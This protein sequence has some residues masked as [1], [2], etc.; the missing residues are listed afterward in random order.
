MQ[1]AYGVLTSGRAID[2][3]IGAAGTG[4]TRVVAAIAG[5]WCQAGAGR[6]IGLTTSTNASHVLAAEGLTESHNFARFLGR[7]KDSDQTLGHLPVA[8]GDLLVV[9]EASMVST[10]DLAAVEEIATRRGAKILLTGDPAQLSAPQAGGVM[11]LLAD[12][13]GYYQLA[14]VQRFEQDWERDASLRLRAGDADALADYDQRGRILDGTREQ[15]TETAYQRWL[16]DHLSGTP[17]LLLVTTNAQA[18]ELARRA[19]DELAALGMVATD[20]LIELRDGNLAGAGDLIVARQNDRIVAGEPGR[21]LANRD[22]LR[23]DGWEEIGEAR[24][25]LVRRMTGRHRRTGNITWSETFELPEDVHRAARR[26]GICRE[27]PH[28]GRPDGRHRAPGRGRNGQPRVVLRRHEPRPRTQH[29]L[30]H[31]RTRP[32][33][34]PHSPASARTRHRGPR[35]RPRLAAALAPPRRP[36]GRPGPGT[37]P[38]DRHRN[39]APR[40][41]PGRQ[42]GHPRPDLGRRDPHPRHAPLRGCPPLAAARPALGAIPAGPRTRHAH[43]AAAHR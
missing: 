39:D 27:R 14:T 12:E 36:G 20:N 21:P 31:H 29:R 4:K 8:R 37:G 9:D 3:L 7:L 30:R 41:R 1:A 40:T 23:I 32:R 18:A 17:S 34:R 11:R 16:A 24:V 38:A 10:E 25:A 19:R 43:P 26:P 15:I 28:R 33:R 6:V 5:A 13:H 2:I 42:P 22:V 35:R